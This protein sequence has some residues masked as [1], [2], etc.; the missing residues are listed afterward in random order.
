MYNHSV[1]SDVEKKFFGNYRGTVVSDADPLQVGRVK[2]RVHGFY[3]DVPDDAIPWALYSDPFMGGQGALGGVFVPDVGSD[4]WVFF[5]NGNHMQPVYFAG[6]PSGAAF[7]KQITNSGQPESR[8]DLSYPRNKAIAT[9]AGHVIELDDT[10][11]NTRVRIAHKSG[12]QIIMYDNGDVY[13]RVAGNLTR[14][15]FG[16]LKEYVKGNKESH[17]LGSLDIR[18]NRIDLN[19]AGASFDISEA[20]QR[21]VSNASALVAATTTNA[22]IDE[23][24]EEGEYATLLEQGY[25]Y[26][27][28][29]P[30]KNVTSISA[31]SNPS[32]VV[33]ISPQ[34]YGDI[35]YNMDLGCGFKLKDLS[36][37]AVFPH[38]IAAQ[39]GL[40]TDD[41]INN[42]KALVENILCPLSQEFTGFRINS[43]FRR[44]SGKSQHNK[45]MA[46]DIQFP[47]YAGN[48]AMY[49]P[50]AE[51]IMANLPFDQFIFEHGSSCWLHVSFDRTKGNSQRGQ[52]LTYH[53]RKSPTYQSGITNYFA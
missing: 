30:D 2:V 46:V 48:E 16:D 26:N 11:G 14:V 17:A 39:G 50:V 42:L 36:T 45:G 7:P 51:W 9:K 24:V 34:S 41:I 47:A 28:A 3:D 53:P 1:S 21:S 29:A 13:E 52:L 25:P 10:E 23:P 4:V 31:T 32:P 37:G 43:G 35:D 27:T 33:E 22:V 38:T 8:G 20:E 15:V 19:K 40:S 49:N 18:A 5:E 44:G 12:T 6:A